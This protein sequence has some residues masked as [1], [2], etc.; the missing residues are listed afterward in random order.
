MKMTKIEKN[1]ANLRKIEGHLSADGAE[2]LDKIIIS[3][4]EEKDTLTMKVTEQEQKIKDF[5]N[6]SLSNGPK[7]DKW[8]SQN[9]KA[10]SSD[11]IGQFAAD[12][13]DNNGRNTKRV[14]FDLKRGTRN[15]LRCKIAGVSSS[16]G[17]S[18]VPGYGEVQVPELKTVE[19]FF[20]PRQARRE[21]RNTKMTK[22]RRSKMCE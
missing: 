20:L 6:E 19:L 22:R 4:R 13:F 15:P 11:H 5:R 10:L 14:V 2:E 18:E 16:H 3:L 1:I 9:V 12:L 21:R 8:G 7:P 17:Y